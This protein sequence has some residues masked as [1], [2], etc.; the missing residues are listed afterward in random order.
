[1]SLRT[2]YFDESGF[3]GYNLLDPIQPV[4]TVT[5]ADIANE[6]AEATLRASFPHNQANEFHFT[7]I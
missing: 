3:T 2:T 7:R 1:M 6:R 5:G 4:L